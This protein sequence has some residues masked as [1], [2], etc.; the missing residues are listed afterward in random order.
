ML[1]LIFQSSCVNAGDVVRMAV[2]R[3]AI[4]DLIAGIYRTAQS[5]NL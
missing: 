2:E 1:L 5:E 4:R 3:P